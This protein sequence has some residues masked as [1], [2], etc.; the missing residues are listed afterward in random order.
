MWL[1][2]V[3]LFHISISTYCYSG[4]CSS[5]CFSQANCGFKSKEKDS[6]ARRN[7]HVFVRVV[8]WCT[9]VLWVMNLSLEL[10]KESREQYCSAFYFFPIRTD[11]DKGF[12]FLNC[13]YWSSMSFLIRTPR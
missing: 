3:L 6:Q 10:Q 5:V 7:Y 9:Q 13:S 11:S 1:Y 8:F 4:L 2:W 12:A